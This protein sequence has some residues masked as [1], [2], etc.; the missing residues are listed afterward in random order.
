V[1]GVIFLAVML[2]IAWVVVILP[3]QRRVRAHQALVRALEV[4][5]DV[6]TTSGMLGTIIAFEDDEVVQLEVADGIVL[7]VVKGAIAQRRTPA[8]TPIEEPI[9]VAA[10]DPAVEDDDTTAVDD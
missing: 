3:Q 10:D 1:G 2:V 7:R 9:T 6:M 4:G 5:D 8:G